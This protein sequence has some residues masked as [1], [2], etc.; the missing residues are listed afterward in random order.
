[1]GKIIYIFRLFI[2]LSKHET[3]NFP[4]SA[5][6]SSDFRLVIELMGIFIYQIVFQFLPT[7]CIIMWQMHRAPL[8]TGFFRHEMKTVLAGR[9]SRPILLQLSI[10]LVELRGNATL[11]YF[12]RHVCYFM[13]ESVEDDRLAELL[14]LPCYAHTSSSLDQNWP[15]KFLDRLCSN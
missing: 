11:I 12:N 6:P 4:S 7:Q 5:S 1:M 13:S 10:S 15:E 8:C 9:R 3:G 2:S 14:L